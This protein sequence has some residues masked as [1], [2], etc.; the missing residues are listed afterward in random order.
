MEPNPP[1]PFPKKEGG[2]ERETRLV[3]TIA[4]ADLKRLLGI[5]AGDASQDAALA[6]V[7]SAEQAVWEYGLDP[8]V[9]QSAMLAASV[10]DAGLGAVLTLGVAERLAGSYLEQL[11][12]SP[13]YTDDFVI[14]GLHV[15][16]SRTDNV[17]QLG[18][19]LS[20]QG[21][22]RLEPFVRGGRRVVLDAVGDVPDGSTKVVGASSGPV[23]ASVFDRRSDWGDTDGRC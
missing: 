7:L 5:A 13:G 10:G 21:A 23:G 6:A 14:G 20:A 15:T 3:L 19:R 11:A 12:R 17:G 1:A 4:V 8:A 22:K 2:A 9:L 16:A 18:T